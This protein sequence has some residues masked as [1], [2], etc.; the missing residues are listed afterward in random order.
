MRKTITLLLSVLV[1]VSLCSYAGNASTQLPDDTAQES[2]ELYLYI[3]SPLTLSNGSIKPLDSENLGLVPVVYQDRTLVPLRAISEHFGAQV[4]YDAKTDTAIIRYAGKTAEFPVGKN[5]FVFN[6]KTYQMDTQTMSTNGRCLVPLRAL[7]ETVLGKYVDYCNNVISV[8]NDKIDLINDT[9]LMSQVK[10]KIGAAVRLS[11]ISELSAFIDLNSGNYRYNTTKTAATDANTGNA[12]AAAE[13]SGTQGGYTDSNYSSTNVQ[14]EGVDEADTVKTDGKFIYISGANQVSIIRAD[15]AALTSTDTIKTADNLTLSELYIDNGR[16]IVL[17][18]RHEQTPPV[19]YKESAPVESVKTV[20]PYMPGKSYT[21]AGIYSV[22]QAGK[23][24][25]L[26]EIEV[27]GNLR[28]SRK[29]NNYL[30]L[31]S[32]QYIYSTDPDDITPY[33]RDTAVSDKA[34]PLTVDSIITFPGKKSSSYLNVTAIDISDPTVPSH[35][36]SLLGAGDQIYMNSSALYVAAYDYESNTAKTSVIKFKIDGLNFGYAASGNVNGN[37]LNQFSMD[38]YNGNFRIATTSWNNTE[39]ENALYVLDQNLNTI[40]AIEGLAKGERI[41]SVRFVGAT[42]Y[43]V[44]Y[45]NIDPLFVIDLSV[46]NKPTVVGQLEVPGFS[47]YLHPLTDKLVMG[48]GYD[49]EQMYVLNAKTGK[50]ETIGTR[51]GGLKFSLFDISN[52]AKPAEVSSYVLG[53]AGSYSE[54][55]Y[56]HK[57]LMFDPANQMFAFDAVVNE[58][59]GSSSSGNYTSGAVVMSWNESGFSVKGRIP[60]DNTVR[61]EDKYYWYGS[62]RLCYIGNVLYYIQGGAIRAFDMSTLSPIGQMLLTK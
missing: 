40:G 8:T 17:G 7:S 62:N 28:S 12:P 23:A 42:G 18:S 22:D 4:S 54:I 34:A 5:Y 43:V 59:K 55:E 13:S 27:E 61:T 9:V 48:I 58:N 35:T 2:S 38:E 32:N 57:A 19:P 21:Y 20:A 56:N 41:Y 51:Q 50:Y 49:T 10:E 11:S 3:G 33:V 25:L 44:T 46:P 45:R 37:I 39:N 6:S 36:E 30:Y 29:T 15:G 31:V 60:V 52:P 1:M 24:T 47:N 16:L 14:V 53:S 26:R